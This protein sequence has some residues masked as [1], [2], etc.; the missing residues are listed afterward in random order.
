MN[1]YSPNNRTKEH[2]VR[3]IEKKELEP[4]QADDVEE[5]LKARLPLINNPR[6]ASYLANR[7]C[8]FSVRESCNMA[9]I[10]QAT[11]MKWRREDEDFRMWESKSLS[12]LQHD[13]VDDILR[14]EFLRNMRLALN[15]DFKILYKSVYNFHGLDA[16]EFDYLKLIRK[17]YT[18]QDLL[19]LERAMQPEEADTN[20]GISFTVNV[21]G[22]QVESIE[23]RRAAARHLLEQFDASSRAN[24]PESEEASIEG[25]FSVVESE[26]TVEISSA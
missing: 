25:E 15:R 19:A 17:H 18:P 9:G 24:L 16:R 5:A 11:V 2:S 10:T 7:A 22:E 12:F 20:R 3:V 6:K 13:L 21:N 14:A 26:I 4:I 8:S 1:D 23:V